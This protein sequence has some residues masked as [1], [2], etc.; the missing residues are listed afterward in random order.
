MPPDKTAAK[1]LHEHFGERVPGGTFAAEH[2][3]RILGRHDGIYAYTIGQRK[4][5]GVAMGVPAWVSRID[6][7]ENKVWLTTNP[8]DLLR[9]SLV[10]PGAHWISK[11]AEF[12]GRSRTMQSVFGAS[13][14]V[15]ST[16]T[17]HMN[18]SGGFGVPNRSAGTALPLKR[19]RT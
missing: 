5:T 2:D 11:P 18:F 13:N 4:G 12:V 15:V 7:G 8:D 14:P 10:L 19:S 3:G 1:F 9:D 16:F 17:L 6:A